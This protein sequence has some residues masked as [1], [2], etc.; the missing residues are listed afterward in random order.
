MDVQFVGD[1]SENFFKIFS[2]FPKTQM[3]EGEVPHFAFLPS[4]HAQ[5]CAVVPVTLE[6]AS[7]QPLT[8][9]YEDFAVMFEHSR[10]GR[11]V[12]SFLGPA[13]S[14]IKDGD[15]HHLASY[16]V[17]LDR[18]NPTPEVFYKGTRTDY[19]PAYATMFSAGFDIHADE[20]VVIPPR[21][22]SGLISTGLYLDQRNWNGM[23]G[24]LRL[25]PK[26][27]LANKFAIDVLA[28]IV[29]YDY[30]DEIKVILMNHS[31]QEVRFSAGQ[32]V[33]QGLFMASMQGGNLPVSTMERQ[34]GFG[35][36]GK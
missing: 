11:L 9:D 2:R 35:S 29:D 14:L 21:S 18:A 1:L 4:G 8:K 22:K 31:D 27:G 34:G 6:L 23:P 17:L 20:D 13:L 10:M 12:Y 16:P 5:K 30:P 7:E 15:K 28:G 19:L 25:S 32:S 3:Q 33:C 26:S 24:V 36:T